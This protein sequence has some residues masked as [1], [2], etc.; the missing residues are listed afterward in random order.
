MLIGDYSRYYQINN[1]CC[2][3][4]HLRFRFSD[5]RS[6]WVWRMKD[7]RIEVVCDDAFEMFDL[8]YHKRIRELEAFS[9]R[10]QLLSR[11]CCRRWRFGLKGGGAFGFVKCAPCRRFLHTPPSSQALND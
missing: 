9:G 6:L 5:A 2:L 10:S 11:I 3:A 7:L 4:R 8:R 1:I